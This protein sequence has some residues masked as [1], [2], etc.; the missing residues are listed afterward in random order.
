MATSLPLAFPIL[1][2]GKTSDSSKFEMS[3]ADPGMRHEME[4][5]Y[6]VT[7]ARYTRAPPKMFKLGFT[8]ITEEDR[9][10][11]DAF[12]VETRGTSRAFAWKCPTD[13]I[14]YNVRFK[15]DM[16]FSYV[17]AGGSHFWNCSVELEQV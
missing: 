16:S 11:L 9:G 14:T 6:V 1:P 4:G 3:R 12:W 17:G 8:H 15:G 5:G 13:Q 7:R 2:S 10:V